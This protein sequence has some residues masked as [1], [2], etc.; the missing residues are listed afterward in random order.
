MIDFTSGKY[1]ALQE[2]LTKLGESP[3]F[4]G[5]VDNVEIMHSKYGDAYLE[6]GEEVLRIA[7]TL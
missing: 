6:L 1:P 3:L 5:A 4:K 7:E 2:F